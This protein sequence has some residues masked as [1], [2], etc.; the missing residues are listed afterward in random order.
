MG[1]LFVGRLKEKG[2]FRSGWE[3]V[4]IRL[5]NFNHIF[6]YK[7]TPSFLQFLLNISQS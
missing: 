1:K 4:K 7:S 2:A 6:V 3:I 5:K